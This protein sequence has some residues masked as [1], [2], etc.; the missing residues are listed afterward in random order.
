MAEN[1]INWTSVFL[2]SIFIFVTMSWDKISCEEQ[3][4]DWVCTCGV[5]KGFMK[6][7]MNEKKYYGIT[8][9]EAEERC[10]NKIRGGVQECSLARLGN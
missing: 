8:E 5:T 6:G 2:I 3:K 9:S 7:S 10:G 4:H 1:K